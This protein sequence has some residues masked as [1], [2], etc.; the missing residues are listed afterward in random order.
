MCRF[1]STLFPGFNFIAEEF[2]ELWMLVK[3][4]DLLKIFATGFKEGCPTFAGNFFKCFQAI[5]SKRSADNLDAF[6]PL[7]GKL[8]KRLIGVRVQPGLT[9]E[10]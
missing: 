3:T 7:F 6:V 2:D 4:G 8:F 1:V 5:S 10:A 9:A